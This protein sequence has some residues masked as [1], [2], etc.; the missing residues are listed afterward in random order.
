VRENKHVEFQR[1]S[2]AAGYNER[3]CACSVTVILVAIYSLV[4]QFVR[5][6]FLAKPGSSVGVGCS[7]WLKKLS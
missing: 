2:K 1:K 4:L 6:D 5:I 3:L 7:D